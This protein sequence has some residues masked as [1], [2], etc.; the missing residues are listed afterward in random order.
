M[1]S[2]LKPVVAK[3]T[4]V[5]VRVRSA[6]VDI[7]TKVKS[8]SVSASMLAGSLVRKDKSA[9]DADSIY[10]AIEYSEIPGLE[11]DS[12]DSRTSNEVEEKAPEQKENSK[13]KSSFSRRG[14]K[15]ERL[16]KERIEKEQHRY[17]EESSQFKPTLDKMP[18]VERKERKGWGPKSQGRRSKDDE[19]GQQRMKEGQ[20]RS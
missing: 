18:K 9:C 8:V 4:G 17:L 16:E 3:L 5:A 19:S 6:T 1:T 11:P 7:S 13:Y 15:R 14:G 2:E 20:S 10:S 12:N